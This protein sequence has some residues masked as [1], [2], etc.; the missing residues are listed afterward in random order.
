MAKYKRE[1]FFEST[2][3]LKAEDIKNGQHFVVESFEA[4]KTRIGTRP[5]LR[6]KGQDK[7]FGLNATNW[8][9]MVEKF[10]DDQ[11]NWPGKKISLIKVQ[12]PNPSKGGKLGPALRVA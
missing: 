2:L 10:G 8:D 9:K 5:I 3:F 7:P 12:A 11:D 1:D 6:L 4:A